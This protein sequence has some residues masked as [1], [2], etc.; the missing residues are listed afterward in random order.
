MR[1]DAL[2]SRIT[3]RFCYTCFAAGLMHLTFL[4]EFVF[5]KLFMMALINVISVLLYTTFAIVTFKKGMGKSPL[6]G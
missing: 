3:F 2:E 5:F 4:C 6:R 1:K